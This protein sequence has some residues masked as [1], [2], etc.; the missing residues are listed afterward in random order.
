M[1]NLVDSCPYPTP[2]IA[3]VISFDKKVRLYTYY[4]I[5]EL[6]TKNFIMVQTESNI[7]R[8]ALRSDAQHYHLTVHPEWKGEPL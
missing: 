3:G 7:P 5:A 4:E 2:T 1:D 6:G 8:Y